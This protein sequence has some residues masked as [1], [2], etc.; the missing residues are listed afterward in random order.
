MYSKLNTV[1]IQSLSPAVYNYIASHH[2][3]AVSTETLNQTKS[4]SGA[5]S[6]LHVIVAV[7]PLS[8]AAFRYTGDSSTSGETVDMKQLRLAR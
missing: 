2:I 6:A 1:L 7:L 8:A 4:T 3:T 5:P